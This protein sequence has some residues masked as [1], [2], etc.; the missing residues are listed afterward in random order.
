M[1]T[2]S[3]QWPP[4][5]DEGSVRCVREDLI[6]QIRLAMSR[7][8]QHVA[9]YKVSKQANRPLLH[10]HFVIDGYAQAADR[11]GGELAGSKCTAYVLSRGDRSRRRAGNDSWSQCLVRRR[12]TSRGHPG[13]MGLVRQGPAHPVSVAAGGT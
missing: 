7:G 3:S 4:I 2:A 1:G 6:L 10:S 13:R 8:E 5:H 12:A 11:G 9:T